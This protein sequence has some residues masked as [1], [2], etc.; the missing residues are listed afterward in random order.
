[1]SRWVPAI[2]LAVMLAVCIPMQAEG[3]EGNAGDACTLHF[4]YEPMGQS[5]IP[6]RCGQVPDPESIKVETD[7]GT[8]HTQDG[9]PWDPTAPLPDAIPGGVLELYIDELPP[10][11]TPPEPTPTPPE[12]T[13]TPDPEPDDGPDTNMLAII[14][15]SCGAGA[16]AVIILAY[17]IIRRY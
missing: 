17:F 3:S 6:A 12:P 10:Q 16:V 8:W 7:L 1:M 11:P 4:N 15:V 5:W 13:P 14:S 9:S 2:I